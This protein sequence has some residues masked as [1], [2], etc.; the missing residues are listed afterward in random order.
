MYSQAYIIMATIFFI[1]WIILFIFLPKCR[2]AILWT[3]IMLGMAGP[4]AEYWL[5]P[6]YWRP[7]YQ[8][9]LTLGNWTFGFEDFLITF[10]N[11][12][13]GFEDFLITF[14]VAGISAGVFENTALKND[15]PELPPF[16]GIIL[17]RIFAIC[18]AGFFLMIIL[19]SILKLTPIH[20]LFISVIIPTTL[21]LYG[22]WKT[23][24]LIIPIALLFGFLFWLFYLLFMFPLFP[25][26]I[27]ALW[28]L[29]P[30]FGIMV[31]GVP[32]EEILWAF[33]TPLFAGPVYR[34][35]CFN[36]LGQILGTKKIM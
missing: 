7:D 21:M 33:I 6:S 14:A 25:G 8:I 26:L 9:G 29:Y 36:S 23:V 16:K 30:T 32:I 10:G 22:K 11:W 20:A 35:C 3:S 24:K 4:V 12:T 1:I 28:N 27:Q 17:L 19:A 34:I 5:I 18:A 13:F 15:F 31:L 2:A